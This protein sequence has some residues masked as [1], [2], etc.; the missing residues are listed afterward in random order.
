MLN[1][2]RFMDNA[3]GLGFHAEGPMRFWLLICMFSS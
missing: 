1:F 3:K 2:E